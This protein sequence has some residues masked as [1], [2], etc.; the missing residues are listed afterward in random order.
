MF[1]MILFWSV[2]GLWTVFMW[3]LVVYWCMFGLDKIFLYITNGDYR[4]NFKIGLIAK[5]VTGIPMLLGGFSNLVI[6]LFLFLQW[7][8][9][10]ENLGDFSHHKTGV[11]VSDFIVNNLSTPILMLILSTGLIILAKK[12]YPLFKK[13]KTLAETIDNK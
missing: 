6:S 2:Y 12:F 7:C 1:D 13:I 5:P 3:A 11:N 4:F 8:S 9:P 10:E